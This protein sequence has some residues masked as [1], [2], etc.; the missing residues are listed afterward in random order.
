MVGT[1]PPGIAIPEVEYAF[2]LFLKCQT[3]KELRQA[4]QMCSIEVDDAGFVAA[5]VPEVGS[6]IPEEWHY[7]LDQ[8]PNNIFRSQEIVGY[9]ISEGKFVFAQVLYVVPSGSSALEEDSPMVQTTYMIVFGPEQKAVTALEIFKFIRVNSGTL[10]VRDGDDQEEL[11]ERERLQFTDAAEAKRHL[12]QQL[13][14]I[15]QMSEPNRSRAV[16]RLYLQ[17]HP[18]KNLDNVELASEVFK[19]LKK[20]IE[21]LEQ[22]LE[23]EEEEESGEEEEVFSPSSQW[24]QRY[25]AWDNTARS[26]TRHRT[27]HDEYF[28]GHPTGSGVGGGLFGDITPPRRDVEEGKRWVKQ[29][30]YDCRALETLF[31]RALT[32]SM[33]SSH[34]C[35]MAHEVAEKALKGGMYA[36]CGLHEDFLSNHDLNH[37]ACALRGERPLLASE[38][39]ELATPLIQHYLNTRFPNRCPGTVPS[40]RYSIADA[41]GARENAKKI[42]EIVT[43][44]LSEC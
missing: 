2:S 24:G 28:R 19:F 9:E 10:A 16:R 12:C 27:H 40:H 11:E 38:L 5:L 35:F 36:T 4:C 39:P 1:T 18:D 7:M 13:K 31:E 44:V 33:L 23:P 32:D 20:Q 30:E 34:V 21:R 37:H 43:N 22:G 15:W 14:Q 26:H 3:N 42:L 29:A 17:W 8:N 41:V 6:I 25:S